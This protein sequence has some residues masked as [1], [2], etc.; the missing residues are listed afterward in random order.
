MSRI[1][2]A[3]AHT[4]LLAVLC[5]LQ[6]LGCSFLSRPTQHV[7]VMATEPGAKLYVD[8]RFVGTGTASVRLRKS[9]G[10]AFLARIDDRSGT[11]H[12]GKTVSTTGI[13]DL[14]GGMIFFIPLLGIAAPGFWELDRHHVIV[15]LPPAPEVAAGEPR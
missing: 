15:T 5:L 7:S 10:H 13:L 4:S 1:R 6:A 3:S 9:Q 2:H 11:A 14:I 8:G 12:I